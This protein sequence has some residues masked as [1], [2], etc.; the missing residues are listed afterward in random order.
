[1]VVDIQG[2]GDLW[3]DPQIHSDKLRYG[4]SVSES[5]SQRVSESASQ[6]VLERVR[7]RE[8]ARRVSD[9]RR[10]RHFSCEFPPGI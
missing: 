9:S 3:T 4:E 10:H 1:M 8:C 2:V 5:A 7:V 6:R